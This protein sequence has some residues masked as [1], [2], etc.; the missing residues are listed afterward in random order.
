MGDTVKIIRLTNNKDKKVSLMFNNEL[1][2]LFKTACIS[3]NCRF[4]NKLEMF[5]LEYLDEK[6]L[7]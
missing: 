6:G 5:M 2:E 4:T 7:L 1:W 3:D